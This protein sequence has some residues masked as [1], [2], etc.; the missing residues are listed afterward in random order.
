[1][2]RKLAIEF[3]KNS[4]AVVKE[5]VLHLAENFQLFSSNSGKA[6]LPRVSELVGGEAK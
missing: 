6:K 4:F 1:V 5:L 2:P 3:I